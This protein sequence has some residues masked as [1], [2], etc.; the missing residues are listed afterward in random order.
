MNK[1]VSMKTKS[2]NNLL[3]FALFG[4]ALYFF[5]VLY[6]GV[7]Y[8][9]K[10]MDTSMDRMLFWKDFTSIISP[11][12]YYVPVVYLAT[13]VLPILYFKTANENTV[14]KNQ[15]KWASILQISSMILTIYILSQI[16]FK[17]S[18]GDLEK[19]ADAIP[20]KVIVFNL[21]STLRIILA[22]IALMLTF[23]AYTI[24]IKA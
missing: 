8:G 16:N 22:A 6:E 11:V 23:R 5:G 13:I 9:P 18:F 7:V 24:I 17:M 10:M 14:L 3:V 20:G 19:Y 2:F 21:L 1:H 12:I 15:L 4:I